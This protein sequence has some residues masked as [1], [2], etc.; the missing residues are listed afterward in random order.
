MHIRLKNWMMPL[1]FILFIPLSWAACAVGSVYRWIIILL[2]GFSMIKNKAK[3]RVE[4]MSQPILLAMSALVAFSVLSTI[5][6]KSVADGIKNS[7]TF[8]VMLLVALVF[9]SG[10]YGEK[11]ISKTL[12]ICWIIVGITSAC[13]FIFGDRAHVGIYGSRTTL[14]ILGTRTDPNEFAGL[15]AIPIA[16]NVYCLFHSTGKKKTINMLAMLIEIYAV[17]LSGSRGAMVSCMISI[18]FSSIISVKMTFK[19]IFTVIVVASV[20][21]FVF[22][23]VLLP[24]VPGDVIERMSIQV[25][26]ADGGGGRKTIWTSAL[27]QYLNGNIFRILF[28]YGANGLIAQG[29]RGETGTMHNYYLQILTNYGLIGIALYLNLLWKSICKFWRCN[30]KY[31]AG[32][33]AMA[34]LSFTLTTSPNYKPLWILMMMAMIPEKNLLEME[35]ELK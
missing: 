6:S 26:V 35:E 23:W 27:D 31:A 8:F 16:V 18:F 22:V 20:L 24:L 30:R 33:I 7:L 15:F 12:D 1:L 2:F 3:I 17:I 5:W 10:N 34:A 25:L 14:Q 11:T 21:I 19:N 9:V 28:G 13:L 4:K 32:L 29:E